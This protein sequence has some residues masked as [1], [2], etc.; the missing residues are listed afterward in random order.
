MFWVFMYLLFNLSGK[1]PIFW[2]FWSVNFLKTELHHM[3]KRTNRKTPVPE[4]L[5][6]KRAG[7]RTATLFKKET[8][9]LV[10]FCK[11][12]AWISL[13]SFCFYKFHRPD[14]S[15]KLDIFCCELLIF[16]SEFKQVFLS[17]SLLCCTKHP[18]SNLHIW[19]L[20]HI[21]FLEYYPAK[22]LQI[23]TTGRS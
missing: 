19:Q 8:P 16:T 21:L 13:T 11:F 20:M 10:F 7:S 14:K 9:A 17:K 22:M 18:A 5:F 1:L 3:F 23:L 15:R 4:Y 6:D 12:C 2:V